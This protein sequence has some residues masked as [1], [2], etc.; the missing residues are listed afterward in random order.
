MSFARLTALALFGAAL[1]AAGLRAEKPIPPP[2]ARALPAP[3]VKLPAPTNDPAEPAPKVT[4]SFSHEVAAGVADLVVVRGA[5]RPLDTARAVAVASSARGTTLTGSTPGMGNGSA[6][7]TFKDGAPPMRFT[8][9]LARMPANDLSSLSLTSGSLALP[10]GRV[11]TATTT[12]YF[13]ARGKALDGPTGAA[14]TV[15]ARRAAGAGGNDTVELQVRRAPGARLGKAF[16]VSWAGHINLHLE[17]S[18]GG[19]P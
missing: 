14:Y 8:L 6:A 4:V 15:K 2:D 10:L 3:D 7:L 5:R 17:G 13:D 12:K 1:G 11:S 16:T 19:G 18:G 9:R